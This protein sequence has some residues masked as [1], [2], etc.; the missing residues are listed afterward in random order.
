MLTDWVLQTS[1]RL[2]AVSRH[3]TVWHNQFCFHILSKGLPIPGTPTPVPEISALD[4]EWRTRLAVH[5]QKIWTRPA[6]PLLPAVRRNIPAAQ[7]VALRVGGRELLTLHTGK[8]ITWRLSETNKP[9]AENIMHEQLL[10]SDSTWKICKDRGGYD[11][12][13]IVDR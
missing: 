12:V 9:A 3:R 11:T 4:L 7:Q 5:V 8:F 1:K 13:A 6:V 2:G 10:G